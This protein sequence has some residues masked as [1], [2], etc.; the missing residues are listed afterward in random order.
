MGVV[1]VHELE[2]QLNRRF[3]NGLT[4]V[5]SFAASSVQ[6]NRVVEEYDR[7]PT[8]WQ[9][10]NNGRPYRIAASG[11]YELPFGP[12]RAYLTKGPLGQLAGGWQ[13]AANY[14]YQPG[15]LL[16]DWTN[17]FFYGDLDDI[18]LDHPTR[19]QWFNTDAGFE[20]D[21]AKTP[22]GFQKR[23]FPF[24]VDG[25]RGQALSFLNMSLTRTV[26]LSGARTFQVRLDVQNVLNR[27]HW[28]NANTNPTNSNFGKVTTVTQNYMR[29]FTFVGRV[30]F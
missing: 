15:A 26:R 25:V 10:N 29:F 9:G 28:Q 17:L 16:G 6:E 7:E 19:D 8:I 24:R 23:Q 12:G 4:G 20:K 1:K 11:V 14:D 3:S 5:F 18:P 2:V 30:N 21:P 13:V 22:A 27:Q